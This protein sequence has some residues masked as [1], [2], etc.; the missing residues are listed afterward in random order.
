HH[1]KLRMSRQADICVLS[2]GKALSSQ[3][4]QGLQ[5][6][7]F[8]ALGNWT[9]RESKEIITLQHSNPFRTTSCLCF[10][11]NQQPSV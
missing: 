7:M 1:C 10:L 2:S 4:V 11:D 6:A 8:A 9:D 3:D 5:T